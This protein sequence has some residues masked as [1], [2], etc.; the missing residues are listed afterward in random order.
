MAVW[1]NPFQTKE[2]R[3]KRIKKLLEVET[4]PETREVLELILTDEDGVIHVG[5]DGTLQHL[6]W[7]IREN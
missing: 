2:E 6:V 5:E 3:D 4:D 7:K 1:Q